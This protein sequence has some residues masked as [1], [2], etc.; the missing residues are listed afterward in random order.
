MNHRVLKNLVLFALAISPALSQE[1]QTPA[2]GRI[3]TPTRLVATFSEKEN[4]W[5]AAV[6]KKSSSA[7]D[8]LLDDEFQVWNPDHPGA[9]PREDWQKT[10]FSNPPTSFQIQ[11]MAARPV[12]DDVTIVSF[13][14][15]ETRDKQT[16]QSFVVDVWT[17]NGGDWKCTDRYIS[18]LPSTA[19][20]PPRP[21]G[22][23]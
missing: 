19:H 16:T 7:L 1:S 2:T 6:Q 14:L 21:T 10:A 23:N 12:R 22:R 9:T 11:H 4:A 8:Q 15:R 13:E 3:L 5:A 20:V 17:K 18:K